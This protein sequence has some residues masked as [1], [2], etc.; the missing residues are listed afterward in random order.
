M[1]GRSH[2]VIRAAN[3]CALPILLRLDCLR[4]HRH[5]AS[6]SMLLTPQRGNPEIPATPSTLFGSRPDRPYLFRS[7]CLVFGLELLAL[8]ACPAESADPLAGC[9]IWF[10][11]DINN[12][13]SAMTRGGSGAPVISVLVS[14]P[15]GII[16]WRHIRAWF[17]R[18]PSKQYTAGPHNRAGNCHS[19]PYPDADSLFSPDLYRVAVGKKRRPL[20]R[21]IAGYPTWNEKRRL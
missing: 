11:V 14:R 10:R 9:A 2:P 8:L 19:D 7:T 15:C 3:M 4:R 17:S 18:V 20:G 1:A 13:L 6:A 5:F 21:A 12:S 16:W